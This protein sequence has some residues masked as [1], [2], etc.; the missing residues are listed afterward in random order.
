VNLG[1]EGKRALVTAASGGLGYATAMALS[2]EGATVAICSRDE[3]RAR[4]AA[5][6]IAAETGGTV[7]GYAADVSRADS[8]ERLFTAATADLG[9]LDVLVCNAGGPPPGGFEKLGE[10]EWDAAYALTLQSVV[11]SVRLALPHLKERGGA[12]LALGSSSVKQP[13]G[14]LMLSNVFRPAVHGLCKSL[15]AELAA[16]GIRVNVLSPGRVETERIQQLDEDRA[17]REGRPIEEIKKASLAAIPLGRLGRPE[18]FGRV[19]AFLCSEAASYITG[20]SVLV[21]GGMVRSL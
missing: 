4:D 5:G 19:G 16:Y 6:S 11:R 15:S 12:I 2:A 13:I 1:L 17:R 10:S 7:F 14:N 21:D 8:L 18:E 20:S 9:G 3:A